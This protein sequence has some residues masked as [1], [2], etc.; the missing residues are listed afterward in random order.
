MLFA[1]LLQ[2]ILVLLEWK[3]LVSR[4]KGLNFKSSGEAAGLKSVAPDHLKVY[5]GLAFMGVYCLAGAASG[6]VRVALFPRT[7][8]YYGY[9]PMAAGLLLYSFKF[10]FVLCTWV[11]PMPPP[12]DSK[13]DD[14]SSHVLASRSRFMAYVV[15]PVL[16]ELLLFAVFC[17]FAIVDFFQ[18]SSIV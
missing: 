4:G 7:N 18:A 9:A 8:K 15:A 12:K 6:L 3:W 11:K 16:L 1:M 13:P 2:V 10:F 17:T 14:L 5:I